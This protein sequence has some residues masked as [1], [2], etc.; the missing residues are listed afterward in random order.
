MLTDIQIQQIRAFNRQYTDLLGLLN[1]QLLNSQYSLAE[2]RVIF[3]I[4]SNERCR[5]SD[6]IDTVSID[7]GYLSR[8]LKKLER[9][10]LINRDVSILDGRVAILSLSDKGRIVFRQLDNASNQQIQDL[11]SHL[12]QQQLEALTHCMRQIMQILQG[13]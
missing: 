2:A 5:A 8:I 1:S 7:K 12:Q 11:M 6:I 13:G 9:D 3:E 4:F 10:K